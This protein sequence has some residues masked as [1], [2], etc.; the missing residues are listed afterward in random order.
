MTSDWTW[1]GKTVLVTGGTGSFGH[2]VVPELLARGVDRVI[3]FSRDELKQHDMRKEITDP[4]LEFRVGDVRDAERVRRGL[5]GVDLVLHAAAMKHVPACEYNPFEAIKTNVLGAMNVI[6]ASIDCGV[7]RVMAL[8]TD[9]ACAPANLYGATKLCAEKLFVDGNAYAGPAP[10]RFS[11]VRYGNVLGSRGSVV[12]IWR[13]QAKS[14]A[15]QIAQDFEMTRFW[16]KLTA[17]VEFVLSSVEMM[18]GGEVFI[19]KLGSCTLAALAAAV[20]PD[21]LLSPVPVRQGEKRHESMLSEDESGSARDMG[22][23]FAL[24]PAMPSWPIDRVGDFLP[25]GFTYRSD[26]APA[27]DL[28]SVIP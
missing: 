23:R 2:A 10:T 25:D 1:S 7:S 3:V 18:Q 15:I 19:P 6:E 26:C 22:D 16:M 9:K 11:C 21:A 28:S 8:S 20:V 12:P 13:E 4:R 27:A 14:G 5:R 17:A 24:Y